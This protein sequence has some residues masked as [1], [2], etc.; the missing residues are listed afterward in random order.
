MPLLTH[1]L[2]RAIS[3]VGSTAVAQHV[4]EMGTK[5][6]KRVQ[7]AGGAKNH[8][9]IMPDADLDQ[10]AAAVQAS[11]L[12]LARRTL[13]AGSVAVP[14][15]GG[16]GCT[17]GSL[18][19]IGRKMK[20]APPTAANAVDMGPL[21]TRQHRE[22]VAGYLDVAKSEALRW[23]STGA[24]C[25]PRDRPDSSSAPAS[26]I[27][28]SPGAH[29]SEE[30]FGPV[31]SVVRVNDIEQ[32]L[33]IG[34]ACPYG[35]GASIFT[36]SGHAAR[37]FKMHFNAGMIGINIG[38]PAPM[39]WFPSPAGTNPSSATSTSRVPNPSLLHPAED[40]DDPMVR[41]RRRV[42]SRSSLENPPRIL[43]RS[44][45]TKARR[46]EEDSLSTL[47]C[48]RAFVVNPFSFRE[49]LILL[50]PALRRKAI[51]SRI[52]SFEK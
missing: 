17:G 41:V 6:G 8:L 2:V 1:P 32:A 28:S 10:A 39:A 31:L 12:R 43:K 48:F 36:N 27:T 33:E 16:R 18:A 46:H 52:S 21:I 24:K 42:A 4:Y 26:S 22:R 45:T 47:S 34:R 7:S 29:G 23:R 38:V 5:H 35:N 30:I 49:G 14:V 25:P 15:G 44:V 19:S 11:A 50:I 13:L 40:H 20:P 9:I 3:F 37:Q 51:R